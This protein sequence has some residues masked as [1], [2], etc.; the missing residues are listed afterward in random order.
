MSPA[1]RFITTTKNTFKSRWSAHDLRIPAWV[2]NA[3]IWITLARAFAYGM[4]L[5]FYS[6]HN[7]ISPLMAY[8]DIFGIEMWGILML[9]GVALLVLG[10]VTKLNILVTVGA[11]FSAAVWIGFSLCIGIGWFNLGTGGR[12]FVNHFATASTWVLLFYLQ[13]RHIKKNGL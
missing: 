1:K 5:F 13:L 10:I 4:E 8:A 6:A 3:V 7:P 11:L 12:F 9:I 2:I